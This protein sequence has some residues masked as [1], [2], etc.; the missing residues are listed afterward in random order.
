MRNELAKQVPKVALTKDDEVIETLSPDGSH[1]PFSVGVAVWATRRN[2]HRIHLNGLQRLDPR[3]CE[4]RIA[5]V[6]QVSRVSKESILGI[7]EIAR[8][9]HHPGTIGIHVNSGQCAPR[10]CAAQARRTP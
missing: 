5:I 1:E 2:P 10:V 9:L 3:I 8:D 4:E 6:T 7:E